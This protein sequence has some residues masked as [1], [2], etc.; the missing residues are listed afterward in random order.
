[1]KKVQ[2]STFEDFINHIDLIDMLGHKINLYRGQSISEPLLPSIARKNPIKDSTIKEIKMLNDLKRRSNLLISKA[3]ENDWEWLVFAQH[4]GMKTRLLDWSSNPLIALWF[5]CQNEHKINENSYVYILSTDNEMLVDLSIN[6]SP[7]KNGST[8]ILRPNLN[9]ER[10]VAQSG[11]FTAHKFSSR[12]RSFVP[13]ERNPEVKKLIT[14]IEIPAKIKL[15]IIRKLSVFGVN[16]Q[17]IFPDITGLC[18][19]LNWEYNNEK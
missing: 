7:F 17:S 6:D 16:N 15:E 12:A 4:F 13:L 3:F 14:E 5:A 8:K 10:I 11:W 2:I 18:Q 9:N 19:H 1:M